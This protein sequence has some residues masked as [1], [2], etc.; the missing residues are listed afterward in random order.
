MHA[1]TPFLPFGGVGHSGYGKYHGFEGF[2]AFSNMKSLLI[3][4]GTDSFPYNSS[5]PP[6]S[7]A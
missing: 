5:F 3:K 4:K 7:Q 1:A 2:K 6:M